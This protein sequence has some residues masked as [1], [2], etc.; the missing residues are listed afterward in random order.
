V[1]NALKYG[2]RTPVE[3][4][5]AAHGEQLRI[6]VRDG[7]AG[8]PASDRARVFERFER[9][10]GQN[11]RHSGFGVGLWVVCQLVEAMEGTVTIQDAPGGGALFTV[12]LPLRMKEQHL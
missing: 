1:S 9:A 5:A 7:G 2:A 10:V 3:V 8:I 11:E 12:T 4:S 6:R